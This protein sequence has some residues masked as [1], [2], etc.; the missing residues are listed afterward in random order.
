MGFKTRA[1]ADKG[2]IWDDFTMVV[3]E[4]R[5]E[6]GSVGSAIYLVIEGDSPDLPLASAHRTIRWSFGKSVVPTEDGLMITTEKGEP[7][8]LVPAFC[9][10]DSVMQQT[11]EEVLDALDESGPVGASYTWIG[12]NLRLHRTEVSVGKFNVKTYLITEVIK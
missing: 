1:E 6:M 2:S 5:F 8:E 4:A 12:L 3:T 7:V 11:S 9:T 10:F